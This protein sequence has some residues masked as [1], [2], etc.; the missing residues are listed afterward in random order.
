MGGL[1]CSW[2]S[3]FVVF[4]VLLC[5]EICDVC[6]SFG[7]VSVVGIAGNTVHIFYNI[8]TGENVSVVFE[9]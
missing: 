7:C 4:V 5:V 1:L 3:E 9:L 2:L 6:V 8:S